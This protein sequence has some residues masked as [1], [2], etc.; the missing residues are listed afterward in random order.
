MLHRSN[1]SLCHAPLLSH[2]LTQRRIHAFHS[3][4]HLGALVL[5]GGLRAGGARRSTRAASRGQQAGGRGCGR[6][7]WPAELSVPCLLLA[8]VQAASA[9]R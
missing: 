5:P 8:S 4:M 1:H 9:R 3:L 6:N 7:L 2:P